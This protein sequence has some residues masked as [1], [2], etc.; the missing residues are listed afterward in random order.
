[1]NCVNAQFTGG[2]G[3]EMS[4]LPAMFVA[5]LASVDKCPTTESMNVNFPSPGKYRMTKTEHD[6]YPLALP[7]GDGCSGGG[8]AP[9]AAPP[10]AAPSSAPAPTSAPASSA[11]AKPTTPIPVPAPVAST[12]APQI[13]ASTLQP[14][15]V[16]SGKCAGKTV[17]CPIP[18]QVVCIDSSR[19]GICD[20][21]F[22][23]LPEA[24]APGTMC[25]NGV[26]MRK[27]K[28][29]LSEHDHSH[30]HAPRSR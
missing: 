27:V 16:P 18:G 9:P 28:R 6:P 14:S 15:F 19:F 11:P 20:I 8:A 7:T 23:A 5:N 24:V 10:A 26:I 29:H 13:P 21:D 1:M 30:K 17:P 3:S 25:S 2:D 4:S 22:C 12:T